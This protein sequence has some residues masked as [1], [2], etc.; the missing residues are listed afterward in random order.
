WANGP[1]PGPRLRGCG[2]DSP[3]TRKNRVP[4][5]TIGR[6]A[7]MDIR[8]G[9]PQSPRELGLEPAEPIEQPLAALTEAVSGGTAATRRRDTGGP[10]LVPG[11]KIAYVEVSA[12]EPRRVGFL[13]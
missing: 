2:L 3:G 10:R 9:I 11:G 5:T 12:E 6:S 8:I 4:D 13:G 1:R 7:H